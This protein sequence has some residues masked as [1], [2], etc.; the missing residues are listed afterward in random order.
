MV[1]WDTCKPWSAGNSRL[2]HPEICAGDQSSASFSATRHRSLGW[3]DRRHTF[4][5]SARSQAR[6]SA[7]V[8]RYA[9]SPS[10]A[11][12]LPTYRR[13]GAPQAGR[14]AAN[15]FPGS[16]PA[17]N[18]FALI[19]HQRHRAAPASY[20]RDASI[21]R[22]DMM[23]RALG[24]LQCAGDIARA[25]ATLPPRPQLNPL[26]PRQSR[27]PDLRHACTSQSQIKSEGVASIS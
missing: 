6:A 10:V 2:S 27:T 17:R 8:A 14:D 5:R 24:P 18:L 3:L 4:G 16:H 21:K 13:G 12:H 7:S 19:Q 26:L 1:S 25:L 15:R 23:D 9:A 11:R 22:Q 20:R